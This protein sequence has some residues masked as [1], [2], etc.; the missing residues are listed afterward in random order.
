MQTPW[1]VEHTE[2]YQDGLS[3]DRQSRDKLYPKA[4]TVGSYVRVPFTFLQYLKQKIIFEGLLFIE[5]SR[6]GHTKR[7]PLRPALSCLPHLVSVWFSL[8]PKHAVSLTFWN[9]N[10][11]FHPTVVRPHAFMTEH[12]DCLFCE[13]SPTYRMDGY[14][15]SFSANDSLSGERNHPSVL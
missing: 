5:R 4:R 2:S 1:E 14:L 9:L 15:G 3:E 13:A 11:V 12:K 10:R 7:R 8:R 6:K